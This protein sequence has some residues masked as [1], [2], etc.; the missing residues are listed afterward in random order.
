MSSAVERARRLAEKK[1]ENCLRVVALDYEVFPRPFVLKYYPLA[2]ARARGS[3]LWDLDGNEYVDFTSGAAVFNVGHCHPDV[4]GAVVEQVQRAMNYTTIYFYM[5]EP[6]RLARELARITPGSFEKRVVFAFD[7]SVAAEVALMAARAYRGRPGIVA[8]RGSFH[9]TLYFT[10]SASGVIRED[11]KKKMLAYDKVYFAEYANPYRNKWGIDGY[12]RPDD[13]VSAAVG[14]LERLLREKSKEAAAV[15]F[16]PVQ[17]D[18]G[19]VVPPRDF[20][21]EVARLASEHGLLLVDDD[22]QTGM[23]RTGKWWGVEHYG[24][25]PDVLVAGKALGGGMPLSAVV[26]RAEVLEDLPRVGLGFTNMGHAVCARAA[27]AAIEVIRREGL[28][29]RARELGN[30][31]L[32]RLRELSEKYEIIG[33]ARGLGL[34]AGVEVVRDKKSKE[35]DR[36]AALKICWRSWERGLVVATVGEHGNVVRIAPPLNIPREDLDRGL[37]VLESSVR[38][39]VQGRVPDGVVEVMQGW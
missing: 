19:V 32:K 3:R 34:L 39:V 30:Y 14:E 22:I 23:G 25:E 29:E 4:V 35:P 9:G 5:E 6:A 21:R 12:E 16:E 13:L 26:A 10:L 2:V 15:I 28:V 1:I 18:A 36:A 37:E 33:D 7:G 38:D 20:I 31:L 27:L 17:G 8:F 24:V 11:A